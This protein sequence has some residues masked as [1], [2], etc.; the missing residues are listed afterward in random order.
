MI[1]KVS[2]TTLLTKGICIATS[3]SAFAATAVY[4]RMLPVV[5]RLGGIVGVWVCKISSA[6]YMS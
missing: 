2:V 3:R 1:A 4:S 6:I 5:E